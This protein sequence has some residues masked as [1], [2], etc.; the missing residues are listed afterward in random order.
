MPLIVT[1]ADVGLHAA[2]ESAALPVGERG[3][4][5][6]EPARH[7]IPAAPVLEVTGLAGDEEPDLLLGEAGAVQAQD[8]D[9]SGAW[10][11][12]RAG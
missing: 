11:G 2:G 4:M 12:G 7:A 10:P 1:S 3:L 6:D 8:G 9:R 5:I